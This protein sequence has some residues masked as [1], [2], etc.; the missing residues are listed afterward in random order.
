[1]MAFHLLNKARAIIVT[2]ILEMKKKW[3]TKVT[4]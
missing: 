2:S 3:E 4:G 1:M